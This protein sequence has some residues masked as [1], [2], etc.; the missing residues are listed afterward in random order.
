MSPRRYVSFLGS[1][2]EEYMVSHSHS[3]DFKYLAPWETGRRHELRQKP[4]WNAVRKC[5]LVCQEEIMGY[6]S[7]QFPINLHAQDFCKPPKWAQHNWH[8]MEHTSLNLPGWPAADGNVPFYIGVLE[9][10]HISE[11]VHL[12]QLGFRSVRQGFAHQTLFR[13][14]EVGG[15][16]NV[17]VQAKRCGWM[18]G[19]WPR[20]VKTIFSLENAFKYSTENITFG[21]IWSLVIKTF[22][23]LNWEIWKFYVELGCKDI[24]GFLVYHCK[25]NKTSF[26]SD[27]QKMLKTVLSRF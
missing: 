8:V 12:S 26:Y 11:T 2:Q 19:M 17:C 3:D 27:P 25:N 14:S 13:S 23:E 5:S 24:S 1:G 6:F 15:A 22:F 4:E 21:Q 9:R 16:G 10:L 20:V 7:L 18:E